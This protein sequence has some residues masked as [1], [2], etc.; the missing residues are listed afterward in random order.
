MIDT[1]NLPD[2]M[3]NLISEWHIKDNFNQQSLSGSLDDA[4]VLLVRYNYELWHQEDLARDPNASDS[5]IARVKRN[6]DKLNQKRNDMIEQVDEIISDLLVDK[7][8]Q[9]G[10]DASMNSETPGSILDRLS[11]NMLKIYHMEEQTERKD[12]SQEHIKSCRSKLKILQMQKDDL[13]QCL[14]ELMEDLIKGNKFF[15]VY[16]QMKMYNDPNLNPVLYKKKTKN[17]EA[18]DID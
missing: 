18:Q 1:H 8:I 16:R 11:I 17:K 5:D 13:S 6:I 7:K 4:I 9:L 10:K 2:K 15:K 3:Y 14:N 12:A